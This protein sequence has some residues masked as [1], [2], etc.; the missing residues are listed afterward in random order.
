MSPL[1]TFSELL[2]LQSPWRVQDIVI[3]QAEHLVTVLVTCDQQLWANA[4]GVL[5]IHGWET[6]CW[7]HLDLWQCTTIIEARIPRLKDPRTGKTETVQVPWAE[8]LTRWTKLFENQAINV[9]LVTRSISD[10]CRLLRIG[11]DSADSIM[12]RAVARGLKRRTESEFHTVG[13]DEKSFGSGQD[14][15]S[16]MT[17]LNGHR[18]LEVVKGG[19][20]DAVKELWQKLSENELKS[21]KAAAMDRG[22]AMISGTIEAAPNVTIVHDKFHISQDQNEAVNKVRHSEHKA[23]MAEGDDTLKKTKFHWLTKLENLSDKAMTSFER[24]VRLNLKTARAWELKA[25]F[26]GFWEQKN[27]A[28]GTTFFNKWYQR[29]VRSRLPEFVKLAKSL[30]ASLP[31]LLNYFAFRITNALTEGFNSVIQLLKASARGFRSFE[32]YRA[33]ILFFC[34]KLTLHTP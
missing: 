32:S 9:L 7:R 24:L 1:H 2:G 8:G 25:T 17:D 6:R 22:K 13:I 19:T 30:K 3:D 16:L 5:H 20:K 12:K 15:I 34:G 33:R 26:E 27:T 14:Y 28:H 18:V 10:A 21:V 4:D 11:W 23:L 31:Y 29:A